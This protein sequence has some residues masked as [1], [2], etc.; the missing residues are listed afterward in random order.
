MNKKKIFAAV[1]I[2]AV[3]GVIIFIP[4][5]KN[6]VIEIKKVQT[7]FASILNKEYLYTDNGQITNITLKFSEK[8]I[9]GFGGINKYSTEYSVNENGDILLKQISNPMIAGSLEKMKKESAYFKLLN[10]VNHLKLNEK[11]LILTTKGNA[12]LVFI[13]KIK[14]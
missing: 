5:N 1:L 11:G 8:E 9:S 14:E 13:E 4:K 12:E 10:D 2:V 7:P 6:K 3:L